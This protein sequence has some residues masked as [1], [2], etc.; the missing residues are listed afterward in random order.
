M[1]DD[2]HLNSV[3][4]WGSSLRTEDNLETIEMIKKNHE[5]NQKYY[6][7]I[8]MKK[9]MAKRNSLQVSPVIKL[10]NNSAT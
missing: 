1:L 10:S 2:T 5:K 8:V 7:D 9:P 6:N 4:H 3:N